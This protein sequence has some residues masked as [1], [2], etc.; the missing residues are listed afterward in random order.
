MFELDFKKLL[1]YYS[2]SP[3]FIPFS[4]NP[5]IYRDLALIVD[6]NI[7]AEKILETITEFKNK[8]ISDIKI[9]D[10]YQGKNLNQNKKSLA[11]RIKFH[12]DIRTLTDKEVNKIR[13][14][15]VSYLYTVLGIELRI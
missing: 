11:F 3:K 7:T 8:L 12:S 14:K 15:L 13:D 2:K 10:Y 9:F 5:S 4:R 1:K 6:K